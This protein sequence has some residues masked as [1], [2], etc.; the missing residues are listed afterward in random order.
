MPYDRAHKFIYE[1][2]QTGVHK[3]INIFDNFN[4]IA[5]N[6]ELNDHRLISGKVGKFQDSMSFDCRD[7][8]S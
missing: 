7:M 2:F 3:F 1:Y 8:S 6:F 4:T 5:T